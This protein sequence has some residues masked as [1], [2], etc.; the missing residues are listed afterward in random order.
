[1][2][3][4]ELIVVEDGQ[5]TIYESLRVAAK[6]L[7]ISVSTIKNRLN[8]YGDDGRIYKYVDKPQPKY[9]K[10]KNGCSIPIETFKMNYETLGTRVCITICPHIR[11]VKIAS[12][13]CQACS[14]YRGINRDEKYVLCTRID[15]RCE[16]V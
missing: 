16:K 8:G 13:L 3:K 14:S 9:L 7:G 5:E 10:K 6:S 4:R 2:H 15:K 1:M 11:D 12:V